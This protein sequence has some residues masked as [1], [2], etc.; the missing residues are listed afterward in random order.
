[1]GMPGKGL[2]RGIKVR[3]EIGY[4][5]RRG[6]SRWQ[7]V[8]TWV[9]FGRPERAGVRGR[10][11]GVRVQVADFRLQISDFRFQITDLR[12][13]IPDLRFQISD[14][15]ISDL[16]RMAHTPF[17]GGAAM[18]PSH[19]ERNVGS[20]SRPLTRPGKE[21]QNSNGKGQMAN[22]WSFEICDLISREFPGNAAR[23][24]GLGGRAIQNSKGKR[25]TI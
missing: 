2:P 5:K 17:I 23:F 6:L 3:T 12:L 9:Y 14:R 21:I 4:Y 24:L 13:Q 15:R 19:Q 8:R 20:R 1:M 22:G 11:S 7:S 16:R 18:C 25:K 10:V